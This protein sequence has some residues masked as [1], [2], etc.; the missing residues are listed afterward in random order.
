MQDDM[1]V[2]RG[3]HARNVAVENAAPIARR[4]M[5]LRRVRNLTR[6]DLLDLTDAADLSALT[7]CELQSFHLADLVMEGTPNG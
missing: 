4:A 5:G 3:A 6:D 1:G 7:P 2:L